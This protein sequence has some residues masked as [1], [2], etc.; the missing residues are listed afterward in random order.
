MSRIARWLLTLSV[1]LIALFATFGSAAA[2]P[3]AADPTPPNNAR[4]ERAYKAEQENLRAMEHRFQQA[5]T[6]ADEVAKL[7]ARFKE[8]SVDTAPLERALAAFRGRIAEAHHQWEAARDVLA[9]HAGFD[10][11]GHV[12]DAGQAGATVLKAHTQLAR[13][14]TTIETATRQL[15]AAVEA[16]LRAH[17]P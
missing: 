10:G 8:H 14:R 16:F 9:A 7:I 6:R 5:R 1:A 4:L 11:Q 17:R 13:A 3:R 15:H 2:A 12:T